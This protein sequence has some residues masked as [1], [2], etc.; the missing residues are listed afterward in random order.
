LLIELIEYLVQPVTIN[1][2]LAVDEI[3]IEIDEIVFFVVDESDEME[4]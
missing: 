1:R 4:G 3:I 2:L